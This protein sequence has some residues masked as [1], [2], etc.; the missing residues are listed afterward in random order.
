[1]WRTPM[2]QRM[3][4]TEPKA[5]QPAS[6]DISHTVCIDNPV[7]VCDAVRAAFVSHFSVEAFAVIETAFTNVAR[8]Y[9][10]EVSDYHACDTDYHDLRHILDVTLA[11][12]RLLI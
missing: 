10:G 1:M 5:K 9:R 7:D 4:Q 2:E 6:Y 12:T 3:Q 11:V 8:M